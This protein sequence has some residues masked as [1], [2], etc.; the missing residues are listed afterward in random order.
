MKQRMGSSGREHLKEFGKFEFR[1]H[2]WPNVR[3]IIS[4]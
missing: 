1:L 3:D 4:F 2:R